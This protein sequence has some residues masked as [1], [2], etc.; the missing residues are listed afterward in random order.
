MIAFSFAFAVDSLS[1]KYTG[2]PLQNQRLCFLVLVLWLSSQKGTMRT[3]C[4]VYLPSSSCCAKPSMEL[5]WYCCGQIS[6]QFP[7]LWKRSLP[8]WSSLKEWE[9]FFCHSS[10]W[11]PSYLPVSYHLH[12][13][14]RFLFSSSDLNLSFLIP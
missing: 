3:S 12:A 5:Q 7:K 14:R 11:L 2:D 10:L 4:G 9:D 6:F 13:G 8:H 1:L